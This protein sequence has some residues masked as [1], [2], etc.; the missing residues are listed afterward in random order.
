[1]GCDTN[2]HK[3]MGETRQLSTAERIY[4]MQ[5]Y[6]NVLTHFECINANYLLL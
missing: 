1:M 2:L 6:M 3:F 4:Q 5:I